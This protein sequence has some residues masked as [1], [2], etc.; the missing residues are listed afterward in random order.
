[1]VVVVA[2]AADGDLSASG[3]PADRAEEK[4]GEQVEPAALECWSG[5]CFLQQSHGKSRTARD[6]SKE[7]RE[8][9]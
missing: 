1:M 2:A 8:I 4:E 3:G 6:S 5:V 7:S 9:R